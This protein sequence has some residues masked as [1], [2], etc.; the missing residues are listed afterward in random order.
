[1]SLSSPPGVCHR[2]SYIE[3]VC[4]MCVTWNIPVA[5]SGVPFTDSDFPFHCRSNMV[6]VITAMA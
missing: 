1:M 5:E 6:S 4:F 3:K 2:V